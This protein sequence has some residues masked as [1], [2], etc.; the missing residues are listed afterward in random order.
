MIFCKIVP[1]LA[2]KGPM[3]PYGPQPGPGP[4]PDWALKKIIYFLCIFW[5]P[6][7]FLIK[8]YV[9]IWKTMFFRLLD[10]RPCRIIWKLP[11]I[12]VLEPKRAKLNQKSEHGHVQHVPKASSEGETLQKNT[13]FFNNIISFWSPTA[14]VDSIN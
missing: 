14:S 8:G 12:S 3:D 13:P 2:H 7:C 6:L 10:A 9:F 1:L 11:Q 5:V 4:N